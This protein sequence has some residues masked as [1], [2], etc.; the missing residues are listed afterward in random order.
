MHTDGV[1]DVIG[2][3]E[4]WAV[5]LQRVARLDHRSKALDNDGQF[6]GDLGAGRDAGWEVRWEGQSI[7]LF[8]E[9]L[10]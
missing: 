7:G 3:K 9:L 2:L 1:Q 5:S 8:L 6:H 10:L 4:Q